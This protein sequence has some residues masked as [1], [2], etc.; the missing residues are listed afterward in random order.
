MDDVKS[1]SHSSWN[2]K[3]RIVFASKFRQKVF[4]EERRVE[5]GK[6][7]RQLCEWKGVNIVE[8]E[9]CPDHVHMLMEIPPKYS[10]SGIM[11]YLKGKSSLMI[12]EKYA[13]LKY[14]YGNRQFWCRGYYVDTV[15]KNTK[16]IKEYIKHQLDE[17]K[18]LDQ[19]TLKEFV[20]PFRGAGNNLLA[21]GRP[22]RKRLQAQASMKAF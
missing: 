1:L 21:A 5:I 20:D 18:A 15:G 7:L 11:G 12:F 8:A 17:D 9:V 4:Y 2:C 3:Y 16:K 6:I 14:K 22:F 10:V 13:N 19:L